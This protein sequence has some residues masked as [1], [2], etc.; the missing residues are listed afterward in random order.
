M[1]AQKSLIF[2]KYSWLNLL[3]SVHLRPHRPQCFFK[4][5]I[6]FSNY[7]NIF[8]KSR[9]VQSASVLANSQYSYFYATQFSK[10]LL[11]KKLS[12]GQRSI[13]R[14]VAHQHYP[15]LYSFWQRLI[16]QWIRA[17]WSRTYFYLVFSLECFNL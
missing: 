9:V 10:Y 16:L 7:K 15:P 1:M 13:I 8:H 5:L 17:G 2:K 12:P 11:K 4:L 6:C 14:W 3:Q